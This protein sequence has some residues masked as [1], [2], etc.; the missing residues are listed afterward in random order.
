MIKAKFAERKIKKSQ[1]ISKKQTREE[2]QAKKS[3]EFLLQAKKKGYHVSESLLKKSGILVSKLK[4]STKTGLKKGINASKTVALSSSEK[5]LAI[6]EKLG[7]LRK[8]GIITEREF[9]EKKK[10]ILEN[11]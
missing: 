5:N 3:G 7:E 6:F 10:K 9:Q 11:I 8:S 1:H 4:K 2:T